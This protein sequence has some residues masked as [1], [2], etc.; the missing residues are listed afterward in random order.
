[1]YSVSLGIELPRP[2]RS[3]VSLERVGIEHRAPEKLFHFET[4]RTNCGICGTLHLKSLDSSKT[5]PEAVQILVVELKIESATQIPE[6]A[7]Y[8]EI[9]HLVD[10]FLRPLHGS[11][12]RVALRVLVLIRLNSRR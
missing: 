7:S 9:Y 2:R 11:R 6:F 5:N 12:L 10:E 4:P 1:M 8:P 3:S